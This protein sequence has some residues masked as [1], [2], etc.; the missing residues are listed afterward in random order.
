V[1]I[2]APKIAQPMTS[3]DSILENLFNHFREMFTHEVAPYSIELSFKVK[4]P[5]KVKDELIEHIP[6]HFQR[7]GFKV[8]EI[9][10]TAKGIAILFEWYL[11]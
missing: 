10:K 11:S 7:Y 8:L 9:R 3:L 6:V 5:A 2:P 1:I 4:I